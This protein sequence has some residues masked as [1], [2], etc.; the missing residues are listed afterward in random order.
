MDHEVQVMDF[1]DVHSHILPG[2]DDGAHDLGAAVDMLRM[3]YEDGIKYVILTPH[4]IPGTMEIS[5]HEV[6]KAITGI[7]DIIKAEGIDV[8][9]FPGNEVYL[10][11]RTVR[12]VESNEVCTLNESRYLLIELPVTEMHMYTRNVVFELVLKGYVPIIA[13]PERNPG[14]SGQPGMLVE[15]IEG[16]ALVQV[17]SSSLIGLYG[18]KVYEAA[19]SF[20]KQGMVHFVGTD[21]HSISGRKPSLR[22]AYDAVE[23]EFGTGYARKLFIENGMA[24]IRN[25]E[26]HAENVVKDGSSRRGFISLFSF[27]KSSSN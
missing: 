24:V 27:F 10:D 26:I 9:V 14:I 20:L 5:R 19:H 15:L 18:K 2:L 16:G 3:A 21:A 22:S 4:Y 13:H 11:A 25:E 1:V 7:R 8:E 23:S 6:Q 17:N 12:A